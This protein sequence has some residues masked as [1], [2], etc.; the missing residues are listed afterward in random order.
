M[1]VVTDYTKRK[2]LTEKG[3]QIMTRDLENQLTVWEKFE[4]IPKSTSLVSPNSQTS[5][6]STAE[7]SG[8]VRF[9]FMGI[10]ALN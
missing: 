7:I 2:P 10:D 4:E 6:V 9:V 3:Y 5:K 1:G 8:V